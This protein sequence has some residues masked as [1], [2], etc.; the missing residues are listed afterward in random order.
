MTTTRVPA[1]P[2]VFV[3][4]DVTFTEPYSARSSITGT[5]E[6]YEPGDTM[7]P[8]QLHHTPA[9][10]DVT[11]PDAMWV[12]E[13]ASDGCNAGD[14]LYFPGGVLRVDVVSVQHYRA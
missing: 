10:Q 11:D 9:V 12:T 14:F 13:A 2:G 8:I 5:A 1:D 3:F 7:G 4:A 6:S